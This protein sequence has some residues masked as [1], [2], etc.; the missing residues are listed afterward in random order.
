MQGERGAEGKGEGRW[1]LVAASRSGNRHHTHGVGVARAR[2]P[3]RQHDDQ[4][5]ALEEPTRFANVHAQVHAQVH[6]L[7]PGVMSWFFA[8]DWEDAP[9]E[10]SL[11]CRLVIAGH[12]DD[13]SPWAVPGHQVR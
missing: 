11:A 6:I 8:Q 10:V 1:L 9:V 4:V 12:S 7:R 3:A 13:G 5:T 2:A